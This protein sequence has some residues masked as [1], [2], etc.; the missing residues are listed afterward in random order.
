M[1]LALR[2]AQAIATSLDSAFEGAIDAL[3]DASI[4]AG[5]SPGMAIRLA[6]LG[7]TIFAKEYGLANLE[8]GTAVTP[9]SVFRI[10]SL[11]K[12]FTAALVLKLAA[13]GKL[14]LDDA[15]ATHL[16]FFA[17][18][19]RFTLRELLNH[20][21][22]LHSDESD[23]SAP[24]GSTGPKTQLDLAR[25]IS[26]QATLF[27][28]EPGTAW[29]Y[30]NANY[31]V[32]GAVIE[33]VAAMKLADVASAL[34]F[35]PLGLPR[36]AFDTSAAVVRGRVD[37]YSAVQGQAGVFS[38]APFLEIS[39]AGGAGAMRSTTS[40]LCR[41]QHALLANQLFDARLVETMLTPGRLRDGR[42]SGSR[43]F[44][45]EDAH[46]GETQYA[47]G[48]FVTPLSAG[49]RSVLHYG[50]INGFAAFMETYTNVGLT[51]VVLCNGDIG[52]ATPFRAIRKAV[53][54]HVL[55]TPY[56]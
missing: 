6:S 38:H 18:K 13:E 31:I 28:F 44:A 8:T 2:P 4:K 11:T 23:A 9:D 15:A 1:G 47:M 17:D 51:L 48:F 14:S 33:K 54:A 7:T 49:H 20:T 39:D 53:A 24:P 27:D 45:P 52:P 50:A 46:Y 30:S 12:Q 25:D 42:V 32:L 3:A 5:A 22:G 56:H 26:K 37:G 34:I 29:R 10:G 55:K 16:A 19:K 40:D 36:T 43:R 21:A 35:K 41:W